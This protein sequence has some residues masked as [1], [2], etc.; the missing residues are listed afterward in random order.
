M[1]LNQYK[2]SFSICT[3]YWSII[4]FNS[5]V[6][7]R[8]NTLKTP[9]FLCLSHLQSSKSYISTCFSFVCNSFAGLQYSIDIIW[10]FLCATQNF[11]HQEM[12]I[13]NQYSENVAKCYNPFAYQVLLASILINLKT[14][15]FKSPTIYNPFS[16]IQIMHPRISKL[17]T[18][19]QNLYKI[20]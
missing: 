2:H 12:Q 16:A 9:L 6:N 14:N 11:F 15:L 17:Y 19:I 18:K 1:T 10:F 20:F 13:W 3:L 8:N 4:Y 5:W 7:N